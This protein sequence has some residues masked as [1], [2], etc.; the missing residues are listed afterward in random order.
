[1][2]RSHAW[3]KSAPE[4]DE[5]EGWVSNFLFAFLHKEKVYIIIKWE[6]HQQKTTT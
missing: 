6:W 5:L 4:A 2:R 3:P 1:M